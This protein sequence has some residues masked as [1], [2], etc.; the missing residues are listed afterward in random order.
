MGPFKPRRTKKDG[1]EK[2]IQDEIRDFLKLRDWFT[3]KT[4]GNEYQSGLPDLYAMH[5]KYGTRWIEVKNPKQ[6]QFTAA[7]L[8]NFPKM[9]AHGAGIWIL[10]EAS[11]SEYEK[12]F[13]PC[14]WWQYLSVMK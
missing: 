4:H 10:I 12:L 13:K 9:V 14:N 1:P 7:Q 8:E 3:I 5:H 11:E 2:K 6:Y